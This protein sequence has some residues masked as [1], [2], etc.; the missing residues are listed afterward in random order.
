MIDKLNSINVAVVIPS[1]K[2]RPFLKDVVL[3]LPAYVDFVIVVDDKCPDKSYEVLDGVNEIEIQYNE[4]N[5]AVAPFKSKKK[6]VYIIHHEVNQGVG[7]AMVSGYKKALE[8]EAD[9][10]VKVDGDGQMDPKFMIHLLEPL[11]ENRADYTKGNRFRDLEALKSMPSIRLFGN[12]VLSFLVKVAS[13]YWT[14]MDPTNGYTAIYKN[15]LEKLPLDSLD[16]RYFFESDILINLNITEAVVKDVG[17]PAKYGDEV[18]SLS[19]KKTLLDFPKKLLKGL[20][21]RIKL[22]YFIYD[23]NAGSLYTA[24]GLPL[25]AFG[26]LYGIKT[27]I[28]TPSTNITAGTDLMIVLPTI[29]G[30]QFL[31]QAINIDIKSEPQKDLDIKIALLKKISE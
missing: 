1:Y 8:L 11:I 6:I 14:I 27:W 24:A 13:G 25:F 2:V 31:L 23:F 22:K 3:G 5:E 20:I 16:K 7:G 19:I 18:S 26:I 12:S 28:F 10:I 17:M 29:L 9:V 4:A 21:K 15:T 30:L